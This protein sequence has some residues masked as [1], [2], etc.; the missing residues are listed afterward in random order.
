VSIW[1]RTPHFRE[2]E[3]RFELWTSGAFV[4]DALLF[5]ENEKQRRTRSPIDWKD[6]DAVLALATAGKEKAMTDA[7]RQHFQSHPLAEVAWGVESSNTGLV[8]PVSDVMRRLGPGA[9]GSP[10]GFLPKPNIDDLF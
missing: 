8:V 9:Y 3:H 7:F 4:P 2:A 5:L 10:L 6:G 1:P